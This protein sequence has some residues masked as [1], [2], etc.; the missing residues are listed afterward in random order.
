MTTE[1][2]NTDKLPVGQTDKKERNP[3]ATYTIKSFR[4]VIVKMQS[5]KMLKPDEAET[6]KKLHK[7]VLERWIGLELGKD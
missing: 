5:L 2:K 6:L 7:T 3:S 4:G 1:Q